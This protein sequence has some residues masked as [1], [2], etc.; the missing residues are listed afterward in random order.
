MNDL[1][2]FRF[3]NKFSSKLK[4]YGVNADA[5]L[6]MVKHAERYIKYYPDDKLVNRSPEFITQYLKEK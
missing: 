4:Q 5:V 6:W 3:W 2:I 1:S